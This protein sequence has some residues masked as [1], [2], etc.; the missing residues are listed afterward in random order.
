MTEDEV[1]QILLSFEGAAEGEHH[2]HPDFRIGKSIFATISPN[3]QHTV[4]RVPYELAQSLAAE[5]PKNRRVVNKPGDWGWLSIALESI[6]P[7]DYESFAREAWSALA[8]KPK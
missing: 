3:H 5:D 7:E 2:G 8:R 1:R 6:A 4:L